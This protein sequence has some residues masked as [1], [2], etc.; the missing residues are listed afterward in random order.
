MPLYGE[1]SMK[2]AIWRLS[3]TE[4]SRG[5]RGCWLMRELIGT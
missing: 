4:F 1:G 2:S 3:S 5:K